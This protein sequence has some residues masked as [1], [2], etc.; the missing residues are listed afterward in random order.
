MVI[1]VHRKVLVEISL[2][3]KLNYTKVN[4]Y[5]VVAYEIVLFGEILLSTI[6]A[7]K[8]NFPTILS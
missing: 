3:L 8:F 7:V 4:V 6:D 1:L 2:P 5:L